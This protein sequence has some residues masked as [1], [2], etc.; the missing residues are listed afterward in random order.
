MSRR[1]RNI[2]LGILGLGIIG[3]VIFQLIPAGSINADF[4]NPGNPPVTYTIKWDSPE[5]EKLAH[6]ACFDCHSNET[7][8]PWY[9]NIAPMNWLVNSDINQARR[10]MNFST[11][12]K[13][14]ADEMEKQ[15]DSGEMPKP[16]YLPLHPEANLTP[17]QKKQ[18]IDGLLATFSDGGD[19]FC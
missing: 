2:I 9:S 16:L 11:G 1:T 17:D 4:A 13:L 12:S 6:A 18:L 19:C 5:T 3:F 7:R 15:I 10:K 14:F 8:Y